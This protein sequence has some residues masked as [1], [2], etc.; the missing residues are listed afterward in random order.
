MPYGESE[1]D[2]T[3]TTPEPATMIPLKPLSEDELK[4]LSESRAEAAKDCLLGE[5]SDWSDCAG[6]DDDNLNSWMTSRARAIVQL[7][8]EDGAPCNST[9][10]QQSC[11]YIGTDWGD[12]DGDGDIDGDSNGDG[13]N[14]DQP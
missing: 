7:P 2:R 3:G 10:E 12:G 6:Q 8:Q 13:D 11:K 1:N 4:K 5:W 9:V 14:A